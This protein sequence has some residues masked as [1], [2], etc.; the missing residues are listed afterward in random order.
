MATA[1]GHWKKV[2][3][4]GGGVA[5]ASVA[6]WTL[7]QFRHT[8]EGISQ[9]LRVDLHLGGQ[10]RNRITRACPEPSPCLGLRCLDYFKNPF[11]RHLG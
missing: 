2:A 8:R 7:P 9:G 5:A 1:T 4:L 11:T 10:V 6:V 3:V